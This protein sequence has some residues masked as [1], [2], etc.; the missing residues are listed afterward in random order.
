[1]TVAVKPVIV[2]VCIFAA[3][4][5][6]VLISLISAEAPEVPAVR[7]SA[8]QIPII[9]TVD[10]IIATNVLPVPAALLNKPVMTGYADSDFAPTAGTKDPMNAE[11]NI[12]RKHLFYELLPA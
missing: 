5:H 12:F 10:V 6:S 8:R 3:A 4:A 2:R 11:K 7:E 9:D 1:M